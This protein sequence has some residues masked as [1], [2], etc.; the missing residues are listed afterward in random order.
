[1]FSFIT[2][3]LSMS[4]LLSIAISGIPRYVS[5]YVLIRLIAIFIFEYAAKLS[6]MSCLD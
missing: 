6:Q 2:L 1:M 3:S 4:A 5:D